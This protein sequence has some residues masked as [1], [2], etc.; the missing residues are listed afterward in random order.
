[1]AK[2]KL[3][4]F[5]TNLALHTKSFRPATKFKNTIKWQTPEGLPYGRIYTN[6]GPDGKLRIQIPADLQA[7]I[8]RGEIE[9]DLAIPKQGLPLYTGKD[10]LKKIKQIENKERNL[11][12]HR[13]RTWHAGEKE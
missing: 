11:L 12:I 8:D 7:A 1:M 2:K 6:V 13:G 9:V 4:L 10:T 3:I 5:L